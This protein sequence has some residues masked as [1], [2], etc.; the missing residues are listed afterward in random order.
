MTIIEKQFSFSHYTCL[1]DEETNFLLNEIANLS[2]GD[3][4]HRIFIS[5]LKEIN[6]MLQWASRM[7]RSE[8]V[9]LLIP[10]SNPKSGDNQALRWAIEAGH[11]DVVE[12][13]LCEYSTNDFN[14]KIIWTAVNAGHISLVARL[15]QELTTQDRWNMLQTAKKSGSSDMVECIETYEAL[16]QHQRLTQEVEHMAVNKYVSEKR[17]M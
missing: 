7:G 14:D 1:R 10:V 13:L 15:L 5:D 16:Q 4:K 17:K 9:E 3:I 11:A 12:L 6:S 2:I 8:C